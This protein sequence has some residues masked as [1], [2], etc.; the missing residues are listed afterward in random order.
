MVTCLLGHTSCL[1]ITQGETECVSTVSECD[2]EE[3]EASMDQDHLFWSQAAAATCDIES[4]PDDHLGSG[5][6][7]EFIDQLLT[8]GVDLETTK[9]CDHDNLLRRQM[10]SQDEIDRKRE[11]AK[12]KLRANRLL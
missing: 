10:C 4:T 6:D 5:C 8:Q 9:V 3:W 1:D 7:N 2:T 11:S 12:E